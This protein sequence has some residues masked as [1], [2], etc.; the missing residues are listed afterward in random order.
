MKINRQTIFV[1]LV[2]LIA[3]ALGIPNYNLS[4]NEPAQAVAF[5]DVQKGKEK[6]DLKVIVKADVLL[7]HTIEVHPDSEG[8]P[9]GFTA[10]DK[11]F[12]Q[13][14]QL[15]LA[16]TED[17]DEDILSRLKSPAPKHFV[18]GEVLDYSLRVVEKSNCI[19]LPPQKPLPDAPTK[20]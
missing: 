15:V 11:D 20:D 16:S 7:S 4:F 12:A 3:T 2:G 19:K 6:C 14:D 5:A 18:I 9:G 17:T 8:L 13:L 1:L 10:V